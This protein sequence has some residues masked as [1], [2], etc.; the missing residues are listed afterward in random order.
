MSSGIRLSDPNI[1]FIGTAFSTPTPLFFSTGECEALYHDDVKV[2]EE[3]SAMK[4]NKTELQV[5]AHA[6]HDISTFVFILHF[7]RKLLTC[8]LK[9]LV[10]NVVGFEKEAALAAKQAGEFLRRYRAL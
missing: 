5:A 4:G 10:G 1:C 9:V 6:V 3:F 7:L 2:Y 8:Y